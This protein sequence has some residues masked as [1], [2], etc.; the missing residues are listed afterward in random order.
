M[1]LDSALENFKKDLSAQERLGSE[2]LKEYVAKSKSTSFRFFLISFIEF[3]IWAFINLILLIF[4]QDDLPK[5]FTDFPILVVIE[6]I[7]YVV[8]AIFIIAFFYRFRK[9]SAMNDL[10][11]HIDSK[12]KLKLLTYIYIKYNLLVF[13]IVFLLSSFWEINNNEEV[14]LL[15]KNNSA[16]YLIAYVLS[17]GFCA[18]FVF[19]I[20]YIYKVLFG[21]QVMRLRDLKNELI[22]N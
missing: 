14:T 19:F 5:S 1:D 21:K 9:I 22:Q 17:I 13:S 10:S 15:L 2:E 16:N 12:I 7:N 20:R 8:T 4:F 11:R 3:A 18:L 6:M